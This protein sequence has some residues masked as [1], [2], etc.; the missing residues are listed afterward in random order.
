MVLIGFL[1][2]L[3]IVAFIV[4][5]IV[6]HFGWLNSGKERNKERNEEGNKEERFAKDV[7][8]LREKYREVIVNYKNEPTT[9]NLLAIIRPIAAQRFGVPV[10]KVTLPARFVEDLASDFDH[11]VEIAKLVEMVCYHTDSWFYIPKVGDC[12]VIEMST[13]QDLVNFCE[14]RKQLRV[15]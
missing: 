4:W 14:R 10:E 7:K 11:A 12:E 2:R 6:R 5:L 3:V 8:E 1:V 9:N 13:V 15:N